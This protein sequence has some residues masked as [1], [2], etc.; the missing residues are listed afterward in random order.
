MLIGFI[1]C[2]IMAIISILADSGIIK[3]I[4][5]LLTTSHIIEATGT[6]Y[7]MID[8]MADAVF[9]FLPILIG[10]N[11]AK[12]L[13]GNPILTAVVGGVIMYPSILEA[14]DS[15]MNILTLGSL[16]FPFVSYTY[17]IFPMILAAWLIKKLEVW[18]KTW[19]PRVIQSIFIPIVVIGLVSTITFILTGPIITWLSLGMATA[20][21]SLLS[22]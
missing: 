13:D 17:S 12:R 3:S 19:V 14:A 18:L 11:A 9:F 22:W 5:A 1:T 8:A 7:L 10:Y 20:L 6:G 15:G 2:S 4:L 16:E 21:E